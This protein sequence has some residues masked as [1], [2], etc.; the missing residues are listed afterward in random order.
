MGEKLQHQNIKLMSSEIDRH[1][2]AQ[3]I[4]TEINKYVY[5]DGLRTG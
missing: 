2:N 5:I 3:S 4:D 1:S